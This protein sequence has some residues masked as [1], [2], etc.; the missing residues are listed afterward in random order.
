ID[1]IVAVA[2]EAVADERTVWNPAWGAF[3]LAARGGKLVSDADYGRFLRLAAGPRIEAR[4]TVVA[5]GQLAVQFAVRPSRAPASPCGYLEWSGASVHVGDS[6]IPGGSAHS[7]TM[8]ISL[9]A[10]AASAWALQVPPGLESRTWPS[11][12][13]VRLRV[14]ESPGGRALAEWE[15]VSPLV[16]EV[17][18][19]GSPT[20]ELADPQEHRG[21]FDRQLVGNPR[22]VRVERTAG[23]GSAPPHVSVALDG[24]GLPM[25]AA[26]EVVLRSRGDPS[27][28]WPI[29]F[30]QFRASDQTHYSVGVDVPGFDEM[31]VD[32]LLEASS[33][34]AERTVDLVR[35]WGGTVLVPSVPVTERP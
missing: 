6:E 23:L 32:V 4:R 13:K 33:A 3:V 25:D 16:I 30:V 24:S 9:G 22:A 31:S 26:F 17:R 21:A 34:S 11:T 7:G 15:L 35:I 12:L 29:G 14:T 10:N 19:A 1:R 20:V 8:A 2:L 18:P 5:G 27:R 28:R